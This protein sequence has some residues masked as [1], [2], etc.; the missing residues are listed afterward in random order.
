[1]I[2]PGEYQRHVTPAQWK[3][4]ERRVA[5][6]CAEMREYTKPFATPI[7]RVLRDEM[8][9]HGRLEGTG[10]YVQ[11]SGPRLNEHVADALE[12]NSLGTNSSSAM[13]F[14]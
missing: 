14:S 12:Q 13:M 3:E 2:D 10:N 9:E 5:R 11:F 6:V 1:V 8:G 7:S 4:W